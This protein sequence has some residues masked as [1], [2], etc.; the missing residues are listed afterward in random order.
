VCPKN[1]ILILNGGANFD[2]S[3]GK[4]DFSQEPFCYGGRRSPQET[5]G[6]IYLR[7][8]V[9]VKHICKH[10]RITERDVG[11]FLNNL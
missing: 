5:D 1:K 9:Y 11:A 6:F 2:F 3:R 4:A 8:G 7:C 10:A